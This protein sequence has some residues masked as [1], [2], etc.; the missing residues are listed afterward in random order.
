MTANQLDDA[1]ERLLAG[2]PVPPEA[3]SIATFVEDVRQ[4]AVQPGRP[5]H[6]LAELLATGLLTDPATPSAG[7]VPTAPDDALPRASG[8]Q[9]RRPTMIGILAAAAAKFA[10]AGA[11]AHAATGVGLAL[12]GVTGA[13]AAGVLPA[14]V[15]DGVAGAVEILTPLDLPDSSDAHPSGDPEVDGADTGIDLAPETGTDPG[16]LPDQAGFGTSVGT[17]AQDG[18]VD[19]GQ[20]SEDARNAYQ[21]DGAGAPTQAS[22]RPTG[23][24]ATPP[25]TGQGGSAPAPAEQAPPAAP[26]QQAPPAP[27]AQQAAPGDAPAGNPGTGTARP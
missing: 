25:A 20:V 3:A 18:G 2:R 11:V 12:A 10:S 8:R 7:S 16:E 6:H 19:G 5:S 26:A 14:P 13:G 24:P 23:E 21:P 15:Q 1:F 27:P 9:R 22:G 4:V 17:D